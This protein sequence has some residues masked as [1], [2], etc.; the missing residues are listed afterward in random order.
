MTEHPL[1]ILSRRYPQ[2][3]LPLQEGMKD[4]E[5]YKNAVLRGNKPEGR[6]DFSLSAEDSLTSFATPA[7]A[8]DVLFLKE[9]KDFEHAVQ[10]L[11][12]RCEPRPL[13]AS[14]GAT[15]IMGL[16]NWEKIHK[17]LEA[18]EAQGNTDLNAEFARFTSDKANYTDTIILLSAGEYSAVPAEKIGLGQEE[19]IDKSV[20]IRKYHELAHFYSGRAFP[21]NKEAIRDE[22]IAD[23]LGILAAFDTYDTEKAK[24]FLGIEQS[25]YRDGGRLQNYCD[26]DK[27]PDVMGR[28]LAMIHELEAALST[29][30]KSQDLFKILEKIETERI[31]TL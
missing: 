4:T 31:G 24:L 21:Q 26:K 8:A 15:T 7:G 16:I 22:V 1:E 27:L 30:E 3:L 14:M 11:A 6:L 20:T 13:P 29:I 25:S 12:Y 2:L 19:W 5:Q 23:M 17:H 18:Y 10:A 9:R 28:A